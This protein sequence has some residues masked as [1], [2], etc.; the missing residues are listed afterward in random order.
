MSI[1][2][3]DY[4]KPGKGVEKDEPELNAL[5]NFFIIFFRKWNNFVILNLIFVIPLA[6]IGGLIFL[7]YM[8]PYFLNFSFL[9]AVSINGEAFNVYNM[10]V[11]PLPI[12]LLSPFLGGVVVVLR[13]IIE[14]QYVFVWDEFITGVKDN[15]KQFLASSAISYLAFVVLSFAFIFYSSKLS[16]EIFSYVPFIIISALSILLI[17]AQFYIS[18]LIVSVYM[19]LKHIFINSLIFAAV[20]FLKN[21]IIFCGYAI[22]GYIIYI[23][24]GY[25]VGFYIVCLLFV[26]IVPVFLIYIFVFTAYPVVNKHAIIPLKQKEEEEKIQLKNKE[27]NSEKPVFINGRLMTP[28]EIEKFNK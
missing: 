26:A 8:L 16:D 19:K 9:P 12:I 17:C 14:K 24:I 23:A 15:W 4:N 21:L 5:A 22:V 1:F 18:I 6:L 3:P 20:G 10:Y 2:K 7:V 11:V 28:E 27:D 25:A 13:R